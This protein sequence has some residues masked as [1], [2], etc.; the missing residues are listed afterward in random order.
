[1]TWVLTCIQMFT[2]SIAVMPQSFTYM[3]TCDF[4]KN[5]EFR[6]NLNLYCMV[7]V[8]IQSGLWVLTCILMFTISIAVMPQS[9]TYRYTSDFL[10]NPEFRNNMNLCCMVR[11][12]IWCDLGIDLYTNV[13]YFNSSHA[14]KLYI[15]V[16]L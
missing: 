3:Y 10:Q 9:F 14:P 8:Q 6:N 5:P 13:H 12:Q 7:R 1:M 15:Q 4:L 2:I 11:E 16:Y